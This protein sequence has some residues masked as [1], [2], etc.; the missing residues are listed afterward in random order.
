[1]TIGYGTTHYPD[2]SPVKDGDACTV[3]Q[4]REWAGASTSAAQNYVSKAFPGLS[5]PQFDAVTDF[6]YNVGMGNCDGSTLKGRI[7]S[8]DTPDRIKAAFLMWNKAGGVTVPGLLRRRM[9]EAYLF[10]N[11]VNSPDFCEMELHQTAN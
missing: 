9:A 2:G 8:N 6:V 5:Q 3:E 11:G 7:L 4:A 1:M 10:N